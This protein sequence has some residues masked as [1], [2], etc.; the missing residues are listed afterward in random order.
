MA[1]I[2]GVILSL[3][4]MSLVSALPQLNIP[5]NNRPISVNRNTFRS[6]PSPITTSNNENVRTEVTSVTVED[7]SIDELDGRDLLSVLNN[8]ATTRN[9]GTL[10]SS[11]PG[12]TRTIISGGVSAPVNTRR[13]TSSSVSSNSNSNSNA[14]DGSN[15]PPMPYS[16][17][18]NVAGDNTQTYIA[19]Q[20]ESDGE[21][22]TGSYSYVDPTGALITVRYSAGFMGYTET[23]EREEGYLRISGEA[24]KSV[25]TT[26]VS[27]STSAASSSSSSSSGSQSNRFASTSQGAQQLTT[28]LKKKKTVDQNALIAK[29]ISALTPQLSSIVDDSIGEFET[30]TEEKFVTVEQLP[31]ITSTFELNEQRQS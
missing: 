5:A 2:K 3:M 30:V 28:T 26:S 16:F 20:E 1:S 8:R 9:T 17:S 14:D 21:T 10:V 15:G 27:S 13:F 4:S 23:R 29:I 12:T 7:N 11:V 18:Y 31:T 25:K 6:F 24:P 22:V 19:R